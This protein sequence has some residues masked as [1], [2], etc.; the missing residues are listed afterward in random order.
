MALAPISNVPEG[1][2]RGVIRRIKE[3][4]SGPKVPRR[5]ADVWAAVYVLLGLRYSDEFANTLFEEVLG[6]EQ[7]TTYQAIVRKGRAEEARRL[8]LLMGE[9][10]FGPPT[11]AVRG[12]IESIGELAELEQLGVRL[13]SADSWEELVPVPARRR[14]ASRRGSGG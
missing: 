5:A 12:A 7:S 3:R 9:T 4:L 6:M 8:L 2:I 11:A 1:Q 10:K 14:R 13:V